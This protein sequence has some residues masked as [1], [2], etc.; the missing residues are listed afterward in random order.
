MGAAQLRSRPLTRLLFKS[1]AG[2]KLWTG[3]ALLGIA[4][5]RAE[6]PAWAGPLNILFWAVAGA[7]LLLELLFTA[8][9][10][11]RPRRVRAPGLDDL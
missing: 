4:L 5:G 1:A 3:L 2:L 6:A 8:L 11:L 10:L 9:Y 7:W